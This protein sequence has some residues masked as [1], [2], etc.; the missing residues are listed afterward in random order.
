MVLATTPITAALYM[1]YAG[2]AQVKPNVIYLHHF[3]GLFAIRNGQLF[4]P[5]GQLEFRINLLNLPM[6]EDTLAKLVPADPRR[7]I[8]RTKNRV[9]RLEPDEKVVVLQ[10]G[11]GTVKMVSFFVYL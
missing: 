7:A 10:L 1:Q 3:H 4:L 2:R 8:P 9:N 5:L 6:T 11:A